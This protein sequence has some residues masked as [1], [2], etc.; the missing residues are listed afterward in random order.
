MKA[1]QQLTEEKRIE[2]YALLQVEKKQCEIAKELNRNASTS[3]H[4][5]RQ[6]RG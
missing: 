6:N 5:L 4:E 3:S 2:V 1:Y